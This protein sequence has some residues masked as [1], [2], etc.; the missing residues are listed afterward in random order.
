VSSA[1]QIA[2]SVVQ[3]LQNAIQAIA[4]R[5]I[6]TVR[7]TG[8]V[9]HVIQTAMRVV[10][11]AL[12][13]VTLINVKLDTLYSQTVLANLRVILVGCLTVPPA[14]IQVHARRV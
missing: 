7:L 9:N 10:R 4:M 13:S 3:P 11:K 6:P 2:T 8:L 12:E 5:R 14:R 1:P